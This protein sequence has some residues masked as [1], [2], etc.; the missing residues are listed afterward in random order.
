[1]SRLRAANNIRFRWMISFAA[2]RRLRMTAGRAP[3]SL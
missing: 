3:V 1:M 2:L